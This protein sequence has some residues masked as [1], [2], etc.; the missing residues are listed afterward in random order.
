MKR[1]I[2]QFLAISATSL[3]LCLFYGCGHSHDHASHDHHAGEEHT[4]DA[5]AHDHS[6]AHHA[7][8]KHAYSA[9]P[10]E[11]VHESHTHADNEIVFTAQQAQAAGLL[12]EKIHPGTFA[13]V[14][15][16]S[17]RLLA[18]EG[19]EQV[20]VAP[21]SGIVQVAQSSLSEGVV[22]RQG[23]ALYSIEVGT[24]TEADPVVVARSE[25]EAAEKAY[26]RAQRLREEKII[27][28]AEFE[29]AH[30]RWQ[31][32]QSAWKALDP[33]LSAHG[34]N[35]VRL[36]SP[37]AG[38]L[39]QRL[40]SVGQYV[41]VGQPMAVV[42][43]H[44]KIR[45]Q[46]E[47]SERYFAQLPTV[48][49]ARFRPSYGDRI[50]STDALNGKVLSWSRSTDDASHYVSVTLEMD[51]NEALL[52]GSFAEIW[53]LGAPRADVLSVPVA[54]LTEEQGLYYIYVQTAPEHYLKREVKLGDR[55]GD[56]VEIVAGLS[57]GEHVVTR[58]AMHVRLAS[59]SASIPSG[60]NHA[61]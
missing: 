10:A 42:T 21:A 48:T 52:Q 7:G 22:V 2:I 4:H 32:A 19:E 27:S 17:G 6:H 26:N 11:D 25:Y 13:S 39:K 9:S 35:G 15:P 53:L 16:A 1:S 33:A 61:H 47:V 3:S 46:A 56:R 54:A 43:R 49:A 24:T 34:N 59:M 45:L 29:A 44:R 36:L 14:I 55:A 30:L 12:V 57:G 28:E 31:Q 40:V 5:H 58:G 37:I 50:Y 60:H 8:E 18:A 23:E 51:H 20:L 41:S 38:H